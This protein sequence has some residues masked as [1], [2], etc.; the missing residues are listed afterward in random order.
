MFSKEGAMPR[1]ETIEGPVLVTG[2]QT[3]WSPTLKV[4]LGFILSVLVLFPAILGLYWELL[5]PK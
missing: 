4:I 1:I 5:L 3:E 2:E